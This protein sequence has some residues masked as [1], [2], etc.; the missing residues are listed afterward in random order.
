LTVILIVYGTS[1]AIHIPVLW[2][3]LFEGSMRSAGNIPYLFEGIT[4]LIVSSA[5]WNAV[6][7][8]VCLLIFLLIASKSRGSS[9]LL[10]LRIL[11]FGFA[12]LT[13]ALVLFSKKSWPQ[14]LMMS[15]FPI[16]LLFRRERKIS[17][18]AFALFQVSAVVSIS[19][20]ATV[21]GQCDSSEFH[22]G[23]LAHQPSCYILLVLQLALAAGYG[24]L[25]KLS[26][27][28]I[29]DTR[30]APELTLS[31]SETV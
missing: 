25:L 21:L 10:R 19:Y 15:L 4:G 28:R 29:C 6:V 13:L 3:V 2:P 26:L 22:R 30:L 20:W 8:V 17:I 16:G 12:A 24:W 1:V 11:T 7:L 31:A 14:Y 5:V 18:V 9:T 27:A 23:L